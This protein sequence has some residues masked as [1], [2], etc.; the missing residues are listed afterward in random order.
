MGDIAGFK[1]FAGARAK[2]IGY[3]EDTSPTITNS[4]GHIPAVLTPWDV[5]SKRVYTPGGTSP[6]LNS[7][8]GEGM[9][10]QPIVM[11]TANMGS[12]NGGNYNDT[13]VSYTLDGT[14]SNAVAFAQNTRDEVRLFGGDGQT[15]G[16]LAAQ[17]GMK[18]TTYVCMADDN[19]KTA[20]D[21]DMCGSLKV[22]GVPVGSVLASN[23]EP[24][25]G[26]LCARDYKGVGSQFVGEGK[27]VCQRLTC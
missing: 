23:G 22:G 21:V 24:V 6:T 15:V 18:Q 27:V 14:N 17:P 3:E 19:A 9:N 1:W 5:Q 2:G 4:D 7:G 25:V 20:I 11:T 13:G 26:A 12:A 10:I 8:T 16:A